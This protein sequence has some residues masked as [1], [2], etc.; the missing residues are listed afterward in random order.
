MFIDTHAHVA[1]A[2]F[3]ADREEV[4]ARARAAGVTLQIEIA[5]SPETWDAAI[6]LADRYSDIYVSLGIHPHHAHEIGPAEWPEVSKR[7]KALLKH[8]KMVAIG[9][10]GLDYF[11]MRNTKEQQDYLFK[12]QLELAREAQKPIVI[13]CREAHDDIQKGLAEFYP[14]ATFSQRCEK[15]HGVIHCFTGSLR[16]AQIYLAHGFYLGIDGPLTYPNSKQLRENVAQIGLDRL[17][18]ETDS[19]YLPPQS[20]RGQRNEPHYLPAVAAEIASVKKISREAVA[21]ATTAN[22]RALFRLD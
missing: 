10:F 11:R 6:A 16:D 4:I 20:H 2:A 13:H 22:A 19:P 21:A 7:L 1:D 15:P 3:D 5:E 9:E 17:V 12:R 14:D 18:L 8:P